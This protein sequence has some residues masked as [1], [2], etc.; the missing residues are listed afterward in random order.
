MSF[1][2]NRSAATRS[3]FTHILCCAR[4]DDS[5][6]SQRLCW[7]SSRCFCVVLPFCRLPVSRCCRLPFAVCLCRCVK[8]FRLHTTKP[9]RVCLSVCMCVRVCMRVCACVC[10][11]FCLC[12]NL[13]I[14]KCLRSPCSS[15]S[16]SP[17]LLLS[18]ADSSLATSVI[19][20]SLATS[21]Q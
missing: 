6:V 18:Q 7:R 19:A 17:A 12:V 11:C 14:L 20:V 3:D 21:V 4:I 13:T 1:C 5:L 16:R 2:R 10:A 9:S 15:L 8:E